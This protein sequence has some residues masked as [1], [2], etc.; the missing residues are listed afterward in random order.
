MVQM[1][2]YQ[3]SPR[4]RKRPWEFDHEDERSSNDDCDSASQDTNAE[5]KSEN[6]K[7]ISISEVKEVLQ[8]GLDS[9]KSAA[10]RDWA[11]GGTLA[12]PVNPGLVLEKSGIVGLPLSVHDIS[13]IQEIADPS[14]NHVD[15]SV[16]PQRTYWKVSPDKFTLQNPAWEGYV[17]DLASK[18]LG[19]PARSFRM[20]LASLSFEQRSSRF[21]SDM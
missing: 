12:N 6:D 20:E 3:S 13:R 2:R 4:G 5:D 1:S 19:K 9:V 14:P 17:R 21:P 11:F 16:A 18:T 15:E 8:Y 7:N 10:N